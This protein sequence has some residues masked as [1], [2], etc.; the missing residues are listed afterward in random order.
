VSSCWG[1]QFFDDAWRRCRPLFVA[2][3]CA[4]TAEVRGVVEDAMFG[5]GEGLRE[6]RGFPGGQAV[7]LDE[8][9]EVVRLW[10]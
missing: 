5:L 9:G 10:C 8:I 1:D 6:E 3:T 4:T 2:V 7:V